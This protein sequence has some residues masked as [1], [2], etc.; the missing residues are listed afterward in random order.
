M[1]QS[2]LFSPL[3][4]REL[5]LPN[6]VVIAP[7]C[8]YASEHGL[9]SDWHVMHWGAMTQSAAGLFIIEATGVNPEGRITPRCLGLW[10]DETEAAIARALQAVR[11]WSQTP[12]AIQLAHAGRKASCAAPW[13]P[14]GRLSDHA[15]GWL[16]LGPGAHPFRE[17]DGPVQ[18]M[19]EADIAAV[20]DDFRQAAIRAHRLG[21]DA[22]ELHCAHGY[23][24]HQFLSPLSN[25]REDA[26]G[27]Q[28]EARMR[29]PLAVFD[30][31]REVW[32][33]HKPMGVRVSA[34]DG[35]EHS[36]QASWTLADTVSFAQALQARGCDWVDV[37]S[38][39]LHPAQ[40]IEAFPGY[41]LPLAEAV[42]KGSGLTTMGV[43]MIT[44]PEQAEA[45]LR[46][47]QADLIALAR[48]M[49]WN[50]RWVWHAAA[51]LGATVPLP[52]R[53]ERG[54]PAA[55]GAIAQRRTA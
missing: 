23:L 54:V 49:L 40:R 43:G 15:G 41:Q 8:M 21:L 29:L 22:I 6:R 46:S 24:L 30:A 9:A 53:Y 16:P 14:P 25:R 55:H 19:S 48:G 44:E 37:S 18:A 36:G 51:K 26:W 20:I 45:A 28:L 7:M 2:Q 52:C 17:S 12:I 32:P 33:D 35:M 42:R 13:E 27:G 5:T 34:T 10:S 4:L 3:S 11:P 1:S 31:V 38:G 50:P 39:G 47:G